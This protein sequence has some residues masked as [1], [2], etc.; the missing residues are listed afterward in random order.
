[1]SKDL[2]IR[3]RR[4]VTTDLDEARD[5]ASRLWERHDSHLRR[6]RA[7]ALRW[8]Q[9]DLAHTK[10]TYIHNFSPLHVNCGPISNAF[11][12]TMHEAG[13]LRH[14][15]NGRMTTSTPS[16]AVLHA[17]G[18]ELQLETEPFRI[19]LLTFD[20][21]FVR[22]ALAK[23]L[24]MTSPVETLATDYPLGSPPV[25]SLQSL[26]RWVACELDRPGTP[27]LQSQ[28]AVAS[29]ERTLL[30]LLLDCL[31]ARH[32]TAQRTADVAA[33][34]LRQLEGWL[35]CNFAEPVGI[36]EMAQ[37]GGCQRARRAERLPPIPRL[38]ADGGARQPPAAPC[39]QHAE[40]GASW[41]HRNAGRL[42]LRLLPPRPVL[43]PLC[44]S[45]R[46]ESVGNPCAQSPPAWLTE[47]IQI[48]KRHMRRQAASAG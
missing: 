12:L 24:N 1:M 19:L 36:E 31:E 4:L 6:G 22:R 47:L 15:I 20:G 43:R 13:H 45:F 23:R 42:G 17:P 9:A 11:H 46:R 48:A 18:Q 30:A 14:R 21:E 34:H 2:L 28:R 32:R 8:H 26:T 27:L 38:H 40:W 35:N 3:H 37:V 25:A 39:T 44:P 10:L 7:Y 29:L 5:H 41:D 33:S 16:S